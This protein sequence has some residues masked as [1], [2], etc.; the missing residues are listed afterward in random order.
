MGLNW[1]IKEDKRE[2]PLSPFAFC[3]Q[4]AAEA[5]PGG[6]SRGDVWG[7]PVRLMPQSDRE[8]AK[9]DLGNAKQSFAH[10]NAGGTHLSPNICRCSPMNAFIPVN[11]V[12]Y[13]PIRSPSWNGSR[14]LSFDEKPPS[15]LFSRPHP[16]HRRSRRLSLLHNP[17][18]IRSAWQPGEAVPGSGSISGAM[19]SRGAALPVGRQHPL[20]SKGG[21]RV[22]VF[23][24]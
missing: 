14:N 16:C 2:Q 15:W 12:F 6:D 10:A 5:V 23:L 13:I 1:S 22:S 19:R 4:E 18:G 3:R 9:Q 17:T 11:F 8:D 7:R 21:K 20:G 24:A